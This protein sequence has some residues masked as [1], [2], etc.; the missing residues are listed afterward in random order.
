MD[1]L[2]DQNVSEMVAGFRAP[3][4]APPV[5]AQDFPGSAEWVRLFIRERNAENRDFPSLFTLRRPPSGDGAVTTEYELTL[6]CEHPGHERPVKTY[7][8]KL[9]TNLAAQMKGFLPLL[10]K[11]SGVISQVVETSKLAGVDGKRELN[12]MRAL[13][14]ELGGGSRDLL[15]EPKHAD[16]AELRGLGVLLDKVDVPRNWGG[17]KRYFT[18]SG[19]YLWISNQFQNEYDPGLPKLYDD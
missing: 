16:D 5:P 4:A 6:W 8:L 14:D 7:P 19:D 11:A 2:S 17:L 15:G 9:D 18:S 1:C 10:G 3:A 12:G 13:L